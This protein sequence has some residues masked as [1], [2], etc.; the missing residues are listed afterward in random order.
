MRWTLLVMMWWL[1]LFGS[2]TKA[3]HTKRWSS[4]TWKS[5]TV[6]SPYWSILKPHQGLSYKVNPICKIRYF[7]DFRNL[8]PLNHCF[9]L[10]FKQGQFI[11]TFQSISRAFRDPT[12]I[13]LLKTSIQIDY[14]GTEWINPNT[15]ALLTLTT[16]WKQ[17]PL[18]HQFQA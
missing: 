11:T 13:Y 12:G 6:V 4:P 18:L 10:N 5:H 14:E 9:G 3:K 15:S 8:A 16:G 1:Q 7:G 17:N 2:L